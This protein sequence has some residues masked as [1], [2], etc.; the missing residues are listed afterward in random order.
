MTFG[1]YTVNHKKRATLLSIITRRVTCSIVIIFVPVETGRNTLYFTYLISWRCH[2]SVTVH[3]TKIYFIQLVLKIKYV[4][5]EDSPNFFYKNLRMWKFFCQKTDERT[6]WQKMENTIIGRLSAKVANNRF[7]RTH[8]DWWL[9][10]KCA[11]YTWFL[12]YQ[13]GWRHS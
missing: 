9:A 2:N 3:V 4:E 11:V 12:F 1:T 8:C 5:F 10:S 13:V 6:S 7:D